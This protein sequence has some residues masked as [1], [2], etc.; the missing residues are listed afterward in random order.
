[1]PN[2]SDSLRVSVR[3]F[4][5]S[6][7]WVFV[8]AAGA[9]A[10]FG[11]DH[12]N[13][14][15]FGNSPFADPFG[16]TGEAVLSVWSRWD[17]L[18]YLGIANEGYGFSQDSSAFFPL[19]PLVSLAL[20]GYLAWPLGREEGIFLG[21]VIASLASF[22]GALYVLHRL[23]A[24]ERD[25]PTATVAVALLAFFPMAV[26]FST[27][28][29]ESL[30]LLCSVAAVWFARTDRWALAGLAGAASAA[31]RS[32]GILV[33]VPLVLLYLLGPRG[34][35]TS[36]KSYLGVAWRKRD[37][38]RRTYPLRRDVLW[39]M[40]VPAG[41]LVYLGYLWI[42]TG[43]PFRFE[44]AQEVWGR[45]SVHLGSIPVGPFGGIV[46]GVQKAV[47]GIA[48][49]FAEGGW[50]VWTPDGGHSLRAAG[51]NVEAFLFFVFAVVATIGVFRRLPIAYGAYAV[52]LLVFPLSMPT[53]SVPLISLPRYVAVVFPFFMWLAIWTRERHWERPAV[54][55]SA[56]G[57]GLYTAQWATWQWVA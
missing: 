13:A 2:G 47:E 35:G 51:M 41:M 49:L 19:F 16:G 21:A 56:V 32:L 17:S 15:R 4:L 38:R 31:T 37:G 11:V 53:E 55:V 23:V 30:F 14:Q 50:T 46:P 8:V 28:Y 40:L 12:D 6:R 3:I 57:L 34:T 42:E 5:V 39:L 36:A 43:D 48:E 25:P 18:W 45:E 24:L 26:F 22:A 10:V 29:S 54:A 33:L 27:I 1:M 52:A 9:F 44:Q 20:G 7:A